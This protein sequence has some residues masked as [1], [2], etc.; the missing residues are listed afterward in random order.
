MPKWCQNH[1]KPNDFGVLAE[2]VLDAPTA[3]GPPRPGPGEG[4][5]GGV[6]PS[7]KGNKDGWTRT[8]SK[9]PTPRGLVGQDLQV[10]VDP[11]PSPRLASGRLGAAARA[12]SR[13]G[14]GRRGK[15]TTTPTKTGMGTFAPAAPTRP[16]MFSVSSLTARCRE[17][18]SR[19]LLCGASLA[20]AG[21]PAAPAASP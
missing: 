9:P 10:V 12:T 1:S 8:L 18:L 3:R 20:G 14:E 11:P 17:P 7:P 21:P 5:G 4:A 19:A 13:R 2:A 6:N 15:S 16:H